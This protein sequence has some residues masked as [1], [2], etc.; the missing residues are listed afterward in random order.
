MKDPSKCEIHLFLVPKDAY[1]LMKGTSSLSQWLIV[2]QWGKV[3]NSTSSLL[4][5]ALEIQ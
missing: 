3:L 4:T 2:A 1:S 5:Y